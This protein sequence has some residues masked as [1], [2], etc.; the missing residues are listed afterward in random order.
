MESNSLPTLPP[1]S[2]ISSHSNKW[3]DHYYLLA[4]SCLYLQLFETKWN[5]NWDPF[6]F[7]FY[8]KTQMFAH[9]NA[10][11]YTN[12]SLEGFSVSTHTGYPQSNSCILFWC[13]QLDGNN[14]LYQPLSIDIWVFPIFCCNEEPWSYA[15]SYMWE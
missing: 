1:S 7:S 5:E 2:L 14:L 3:S 12:H 8:Y 15:K 4:V 13:F 11:L 10:V 6:F 9:Y